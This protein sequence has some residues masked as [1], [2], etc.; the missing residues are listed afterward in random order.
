MADRTTTLAATCDWSSWTK[1]PTQWP[2]VSFDRGCKDSWTLPPARLSTRAL[3]D[4]QRKTHSLA[5][6]ILVTTKFDLVPH[7]RL[8]HTLGRSCLPPKMTLDPSQGLSSVLDGQ[9]QLSIFN[10]FE[11]LLEDRTRSVTECNQIVARDQWNRANFFG[12][13]VSQIV[14]G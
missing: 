10:R 2:Q 6:P 13:Q 8:L 3:E 9:I 7:L 11:N 5:Y 4:S 12:L 1:W 14:P